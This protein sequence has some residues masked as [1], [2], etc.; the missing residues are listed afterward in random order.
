MTYRLRLEL[1][2]LSV[3]VDNAD[4]A[5]TLAHL[6]QG[7]Y[8]PSSGSILVDGN[9]IS[10]FNQHLCGAACPIDTTNHFLA[11]L[12]EIT[13]KKFFQTQIMIVS[14]GLNY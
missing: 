3:S 10:T 7:L 12:F 13:S 14:L 5:N 8:P 11:E 1:M 4:A 6:L 9:D 2:K